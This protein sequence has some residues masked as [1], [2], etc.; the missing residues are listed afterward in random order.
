MTDQLIA[1]EGNGTAASMRRAST[2]W[3]MLLTIA[4]TATTL[5]LACATPFPALAAIA[6]TQMRR[7]DGLVLM[8]LTWIASQAVGFCVLDYPHDAKTTAWA[9]ALGMAAVVSALAARW[10][11][12]RVS[13]SR[14]LARIAVAYAAAAVAF[15]LVIL[16]WSF[17]LGG[18]ATTL[19]PAINARQ[20]VRNAAILVGLWAAYRALVAAGVPGAPREAAAVA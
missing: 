8:A 16:L 3:I 19:S 1:S 14:P 20:L 11:A 9:V 7:R 18:V 10:V 5:A 6:A 13:P 12:D 4:S 17:G 15:K 2:L